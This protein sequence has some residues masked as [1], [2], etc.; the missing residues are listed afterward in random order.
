MY[1]HL[2]NA[3]ALPTAPEWPQQA[4]TFSTK[5]IHREAPRTKSQLTKSLRVRFSPQCTDM[6]HD[7]QTH[8]R[9]QNLITASHHPTNQHMTNNTTDKPH[10][11]ETCPT[12]LR[13]TL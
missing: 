10:N 2:E 11:R 4:Q 9:T 13:D 6:L 1:K 3:Q 7:T 12:P 5:Q 8:L